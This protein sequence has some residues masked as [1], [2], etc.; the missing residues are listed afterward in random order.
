VYF[1]VENNNSQIANL[2]TGQAGKYQKAKS[3][4]QAVCKRFVFWNLSICK[5]GIYLP[6]GSQV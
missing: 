3:K 6:N 4:I 2:P 5:I 1:L